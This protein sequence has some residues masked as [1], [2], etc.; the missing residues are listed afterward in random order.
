MQDILLVIC[1]AAAFVFCFF[2]F[3]RAR[4]FMRENEKAFLSAPVNGQSV[5]HIALSD[6]MTVGCLSGYLDSFQRT[7]PDIE[8]VLCSGDNRWITEQFS[9]NELDMAFVDV[10]QPLDDRSDARSAVIDLCRGDIS[11]SPAL[12]VAPA[13]PRCVSQC[14][15]WKRNA[16]DGAAE[17]LAELIVSYSSENTGITEQKKA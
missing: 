5:L 2:L 1:V 11:A 6:P 8:V 14:M 16:C 13:E 4:N 17:A 10:F 7:H 9:I 3:T 12:C 15:A